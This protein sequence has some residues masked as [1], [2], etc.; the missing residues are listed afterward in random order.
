MRS[1]VTSAVL[2]AAF[3]ASAYAASPSRGP[4]VL[5][6]DSPSSLV[7]VRV[8]VPAGSAQDPAGK[9]G[10]AALTAD[11]VI[12]G[13]FGDPKAP[14]TKEALAE[15]TRP[16]GEGARPRAIL[17]K[18][19]TVFA[20]TVPEE[21]LS[22]FLEKILGPMFT[23]PLFAVA[24]LERLKTER[25]VMLSRL[26]FEA[27]EE[28]GLRA[29]DNLLHAGTAL[30]H[31]DRGTALGI[32]SVAVADVQSFYAT[33]YRSDKLRVALGTAKESVTAAVS[34]ALAGAGGATP[35]S[36][37][38]RR[39]AA[40]PRP[41]GR[42]L[43][44]V[45]MPEAISSGIHAG[46]PIEVTRAHPDYW[47]LYVANVWLGTHRDS[48]AHLYTVIRE[49]RGYNYGDYSYIEWMQNRPGQLFPPPN[50]PR[51]R[52]DFTMWVRPVAHDYVV[53]L[54]KA[55]LFELD[56]LLARGLSEEQVALAKTKAKVLYL[57]L[58]ED[59]D[60]RVAYRLDDDFYALK[61][62]YLDQYLAAVDA[63]TAE[64]VNLALRKHLQTRD[65]AF[66][67]TT[68]DDM[69]PKLADAVARGGLAWGKGPKEY[70]VEQK[71]GVYLVKPEQLEI[72]RRD[73]AWAGYP[74]RIPRESIRIVKA[75]DAFEK[76][77]A[78]P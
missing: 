9:E 28:M 16:W 72:L 47:P 2:L 12:E 66:V 73:G 13:S 8:A 74:L 18:E 78:V 31:H 65:V 24:E 22:S 32:K 62:P 53:H 71:D 36:L 37:A 51:S 21:K 54:M 68:D 20:M 17:G 33:F 46:F 75:A 63:V 44:I 61:E 3:G 5:T 45:T 38:A 40:A 11:L 59:N 60:R 67:V 43:T 10:L 70:N 7:A 77:T 25:A 27:Q 42:S 14:T 1:Q 6:V 15:I 29:T 55:L 23:K 30:A 57:S 52:Q 34:R 58:A 49:E 69:A 26:R 19:M 41:S 76:G 39:P 64:Q 4:K 50:Y 35:A 56:E 48:F